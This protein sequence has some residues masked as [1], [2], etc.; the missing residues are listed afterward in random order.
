MS[1]KE[2]RSKM[3][4]LNSIARMNLWSSLRH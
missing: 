4:P 1:P 3:K 2:H